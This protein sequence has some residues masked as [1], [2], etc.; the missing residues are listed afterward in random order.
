MF[1]QTLLLLLTNGLTQ[2]W[3]FVFRSNPR[4]CVRLKPHT[5]SFT[6]TNTRCEKHCSVSWHCKHTYDLQVL[7]LKAPTLDTHWHRG[8]SGCCPL[9][10]VLPAILGQRLLWMGG[11]FEA[12]GG[13]GCLVRH[14]LP[15]NVAFSPESDLLQHKHAATDQKP[16]KVI[17]CTLG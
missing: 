5:C 7:T 1:N 14:T 9:A 3:L 6:H 4:C 2:F 17:T 16:S 13:D 10:V 11:A 12:L 8:R 15:H